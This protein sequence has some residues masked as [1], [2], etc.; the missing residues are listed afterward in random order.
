MLSEPYEGGPD[1]TRSFKVLSPGTV[2][3]HYEIIEKIG[4]GGHGCGV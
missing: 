1:E 4:E 3:S 2:I